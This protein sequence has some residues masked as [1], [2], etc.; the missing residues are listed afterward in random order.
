MVDEW[1]QVKLEDV[2]HELTVG[3]VGSMT[4]E[5][6]ESGVPFLR[7]KNVN[8]LNINTN[9]IK[10]I[11]DGFH[12]RISK[13][14]LTPG[15]VVIVRT[16]KPGTCAVVPNWLIDANCS[17]L[18]IVRCGPDI[19][20][21]FL[22]YYINTVATGH[23]YAHLVGAVQQHFNVG[24]AR[25]L[26][27][28]L[29]PIAEQEKIVRIL[30]AIDDKIELNRRMN[31]T[32]EAMAQTLFK[33][34]FVDF[35][36]VI[37]N[38]LAAGIEIPDAL[39]GRADTRQTL[40]EDRKLLPEAIR[41]QFPSSFDYSEEMGWIPEGWE[42]KTLD[43]ATSLIID[44]RGKTPKK[45]GGEW[46]M[47][48]Y[49]AISAKNIKSRR[50]VRPETIRFVDDELYA[51]WMKDP[52]QPGDIVM[53]SEA[54]LGELYYISGKNDFL[55]SQRLYGIRANKNIG[56]GNYLFHWFQ[57][58]RAQSDLSNR[59]TGTT[60]VGIRQSEL[61]KVTVLCPHTELSDL[62][63]NHADEYLYKIA[64]NVFQ[65][66]DLAKLRDIL[67]PKL[68]SGE[69]RIPDAEKLIQDVT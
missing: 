2:A 11:S 18:V 28:N 6:I 57:T 26:K 31:E 55:L 62:F 4:S 25:S 68:L 38:A 67:L 39:Q 12:K 51:K 58:K 14:R 7:S 22:A 8:P 48:G 49:P 29:P 21:R 40:G 16:G 45:M 15:D 32:L 41:Q 27:I 3:Y 17:D 65:N 35:D 43:E 42:E 36:P 53:T 13:S 9:D 10:Y 19:N 60:V 66:D 47:S 34:W 33:S 50:L 20:N 23:V 61:R 64:Q 30:G 52:L 56:N 63:S 46:S 44:H 37:D 69:L 59:A 24:S 5:Y 54:P 1:R